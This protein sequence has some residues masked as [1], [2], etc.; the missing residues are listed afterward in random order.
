MDEIMPDPEGVRKA[1]DLILG[2]GSGVEYQTSLKTELDPM[3]R[4]IHTRPYTYSAES[5]QRALDV[6]NTENPWRRGIFDYI[7]Q[8]TGNPQLAA[9]L[10]PLADYTPVLGSILAL[11]DVEQMA[12]DIPDEYRE[13]DYLGAAGLLGQTGA[14]AAR[15]ALGLMPV[16]SPAFG[17]IRSMMR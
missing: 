5:L 16:T 15:A 9:Q 1:Y 14:T 13:G 8:E 10:T 4:A 6:S 3:G 12:R 7:L 11:K 2:D 17:A